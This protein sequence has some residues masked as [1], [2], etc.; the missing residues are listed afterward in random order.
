M[1]S[2]PYVIAYLKCITSKIYYREALEITKYANAENF[3]IRTNAVEGNITTLKKLLREALKIKK[4]AEYTF[5]YK[6]Q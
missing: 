2:P 4:H 5:F 1:H 6:N 3:F